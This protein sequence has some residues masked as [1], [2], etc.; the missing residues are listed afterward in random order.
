MPSK[1]RVLNWLLCDSSSNKMSKLLLF[2]R[3]LVRVYLQRYSYRK[4][5]DVSCTP[6]P[7]GSEKKRSH[8]SLTSAKCFMSSS[9][10]MPPIFF[11]TRHA[12]SR[13]YFIALV[14]LCRSATELLCRSATEL[15]CRSATELL[16]R[17][18]TEQGL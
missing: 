4:S 12:F 7:N 15:L 13:L 16:C 14:L 1:N 18:A 6:P 8:V 11:A 9:S 3:L 10:R 17:S 2:N 5:C